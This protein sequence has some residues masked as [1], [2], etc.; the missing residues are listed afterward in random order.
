MSSSAPFQDPSLER[1]RPLLVRIEPRARA[2]TSGL[3]P[4]RLRT[5]PPDG[6]W[7]V[8][9]VFE[10]LCR[11]HDTYLDRVLPQ[12]IAQ[13]KGRPAPSRPFRPSLLGGFMISA[14]KES[15]RRRLPTTRQLDVQGEIR[16]GVLEAFLEGVHK[17]ESQMREADG[18]DLTVAFQSPISPIIRLRLGDAFAILAEHAHRHL[19][20]AE[21]AR[22]AIGG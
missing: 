9:E 22:E 14:L 11:S 6:G 19:A 16:D 2:V 4:E 17:L 12:A 1:L 15:N 18:F 7:S 21:R 5:R 8:A 3:S 13:A 20:Q 10:H